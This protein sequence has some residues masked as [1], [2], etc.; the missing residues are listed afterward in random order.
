[1]YSALSFLWK[2]IP[3]VDSETKTIERDKIRQRDLF[4]LPRGHPHHARAIKFLH[5]SFAHAIFPA[6]PS[7]KPM[8]ELQFS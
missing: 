6:R 8:Y 3:N 2:Y 7:T 1:M 5:D 4:P